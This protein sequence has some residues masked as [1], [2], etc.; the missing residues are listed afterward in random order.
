MH[1]MGYDGLNVSHNSQNT[2]NLRDCNSQSAEFTRVAGSSMS[3]INAGPVINRM[4]Q[5]AGVDTDIALG[6]LFGLGTSAV[7]GWRQR[8]KVPYEECVILAQRKSVSVDWLLFGIGAL[9]I[10]E[11]AAA[12]GEEDSDPRLQRMLSFFRTWMATHEEDSKAWLEM[13]L[14][15]AIPEYAD[16]LATR[17]QN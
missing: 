8:N 16:H 9:H 7:S 6:A 14:A 4:R 11:G 15:R 3:K 5:A 10:A 13:Q 1:G 12:A 2:R 17:R